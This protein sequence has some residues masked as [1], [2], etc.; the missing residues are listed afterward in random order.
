M[1]STVAQNKAHRTDITWIKSAGKSFT[2]GGE[3]Y[4]SEYVNPFTGQ[5]I[6]K[7]WRMTGQDWVIFAADGS[8]MGRA[9]SLTQAKYEAGK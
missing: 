7:D 4:I 9:H 1:H 3:R 5:A 2:A 6:R 8:I